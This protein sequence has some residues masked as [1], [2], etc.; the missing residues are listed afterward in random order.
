[1][2]NDPDPPVLATRRGL[3][4]PARWEILAIVMA[5]VNGTIFMDD[6]LRLKEAEGACRVVIIFAIV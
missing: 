3:H 5:C 2:A 6:L 1:V 4:A